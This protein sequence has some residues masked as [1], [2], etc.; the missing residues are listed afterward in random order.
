MKKQDEERDEMGKESEED[1]TDMLQEFIGDQDKEDI[2][3]WD[4]DD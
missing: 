3:D 4:E 2:I 1:E